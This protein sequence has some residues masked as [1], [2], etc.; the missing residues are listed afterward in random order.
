MTDEVFEF[1]GPNVPET[2]LTRREPDVA[3]GASRGKFGAHGGPVRGEGGCAALTRRLRPSR[4][5]AQF[6][7]NCDG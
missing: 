6:E 1:T 3:V 2:Q 4:W 7:V 5:A